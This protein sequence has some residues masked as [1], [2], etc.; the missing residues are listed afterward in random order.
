MCLLQAA[1]KSSGDD[2]EAMR[3][4]DL[5]YDTA[6]ISSGFTVSDLYCISIL[7]LLWVE[8]MTN[9]VAKLNQ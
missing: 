7:Q 8:N 3:A 1:C 4:I 5:L 2:E 9:N 6:L